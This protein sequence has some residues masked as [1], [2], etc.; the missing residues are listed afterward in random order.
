MSESINA[1]N[2]EKTAQ[3]AR[4]AGAPKKSQPAQQTPTQ[5][6][7]P[8][9]KR[10]TEPQA[11]ERPQHMTYNRS[12]VSGWQFAIATVAA[13][14]IGVL[15]LILPQ[16]LLIGPR[17]LLLVFEVV[18]LAPHT[19]AH[20][21]GYHISHR[22]E[23]LLAYVLLGALTLE[24]VT[25]LIKLVQNLGALSSHELLTS[26]ILLWGTNT[27]VFSSWYWQTDGDGPV[28]RHHR[29]HE[30]IDFRFPQQDGE[31]TR[32]WRPGFIDYLFLAFCTATAL[33][34]ADTIPLTHRAKILM[35]VESLLSMMVIVLLLA[36]FVNIVQ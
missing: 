18:L 21:L 19:M 24:L 27:L 34:P 4:N 3:T 9:P 23:R 28:N 25:S 16:S 2:R 13:L 1:N 7:A 12:V 5:E 29:N 6:V 30:P 20:V 17:W 8:T 36:R 10:A 22:I 32:D 11:P 31:A 33:S 15:Y 35:M 26:G 14:L